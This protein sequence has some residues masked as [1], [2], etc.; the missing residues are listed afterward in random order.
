MCVCVGGKHSYFQ[1]KYAFIFGAFR[2]WKQ[3]KLILL[4]FSDLSVDIMLHLF[5]CLCIHNFIYLPLDFFL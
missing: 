5:M 1:I 4:R 3:R 2:I